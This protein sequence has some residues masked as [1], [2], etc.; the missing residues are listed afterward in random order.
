MTI[1]EQ[2]ELA[3]TADLI[4]VNQLALLLQYNPDTVYRKAAQGKIP[5]AIREGRSWRFIRTEIE[6]WITTTL[7]THPSPKA[8]YRI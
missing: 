2:M 4:T 7:R 8:M 3:K 6:G 1:K 5:G